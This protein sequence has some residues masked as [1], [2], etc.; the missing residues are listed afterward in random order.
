VCGVGEG[1]L[2]MVRPGHGPPL[3][4]GEAPANRPSAYPLAAAPQAPA[5]RPAH[6]SRPRRRCPPT[7]VSHFFC[8]VQAASCVSISEEVRYH[9]IG[10]PAFFRKRPTRG[11]G[12][13]NARRAPLSFTVW[14]PP[15]LAP[16]RPLPRETRREDAAQRSSTS[17]PG[18][19]RPATPS[20]LGDDCR[21]GGADVGVSSGS[22]LGWRPVS[23]GASA[24]G[25]R[26]DGR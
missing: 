16:P 17:F 15:P 12:A 4:C 25:W 7:S 6:F 26:G 5:G 8:P 19:V 20:C 23:A 1:E 14:P 9:V 21:G 13:P 3:P 22:A 11:Q 2:D 24:L 10:R 18:A